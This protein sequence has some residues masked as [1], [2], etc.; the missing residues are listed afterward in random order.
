MVKGSFY[1][2]FTIYHSPR[3]NAERLGSPRPPAEEPDE[4]GARD[5]DRREEVG[6]QAQDERDG[7]A[8]DRPRPEDE[9]EERGDDGRHVRVDDGGERALEPLID[10]RGDGLAREH[11]LADAL[12]DEDV[13][14][15]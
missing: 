7:E 4:D 1:L 15:H 5:V 2:P 8:A 3:L 6:D 13:G 10:G 12:E 11:L 14:V 9:E